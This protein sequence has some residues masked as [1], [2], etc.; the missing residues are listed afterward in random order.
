M[1]AQRRVKTPRPLIVG[2]IASPADL[3]RALHI[4]KSP[5]L[6][7]LRLDCIGDLVNEEEFSTLCAPLIVTARDPREGGANNL[8]IQKRQKLLRRFLPQAAFI[9]IELRSANALRST[10]A[11]ARKQSVGLILSFH[12]FQSTPSLG[13]LR[14]MARKAKSL[15]ADVFKVAT[16]TDTPE[17][18]TRLLD[19]IGNTNLDLPLSVMGIGNLGLKS[20]RE[21][22][23]RGSILNYAHLGRSL[24]PGQSSLEHL[25]VYQRKL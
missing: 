14:A 22:M 15:G 25:R 7:E 9:D 18:L 20:R 16:R 12:D 17:Q 2:V 24:T 1:T 13:S 8:P 19:F 5:D 6:F 23:R 4:G 10:V 3:E 11:L 21:L